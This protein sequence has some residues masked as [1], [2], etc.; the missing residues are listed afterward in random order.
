MA[1]AVDGYSALREA[2]KSSNGEP[3]IVGWGIGPPWPEVEQH[4]RENQDA[5]REEAANHVG[6]ESLALPGVDS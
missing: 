6:R 2:E 4:H 1:R 3:S 5:E